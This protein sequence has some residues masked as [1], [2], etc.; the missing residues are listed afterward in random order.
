MA[1]ATFSGCVVRMED[2]NG[3]G[4]SGG[5]S[6]QPCAAEALSDAELTAI[7]EQARTNLVA[8]GTEL[9]RDTWG[10]ATKFGAF[11]AE[12]YALAGCSPQSGL[13]QQALHSDD[14]PDFYCGSGHGLEKLAT[15][16]V[17]QCMNDACRLHDACYAMCDGP[18][19]GCEFDSNMAPCDE[20]F[21][22]QIEACPSEPGT[23]L[24]SGMVEF[25][26]NILYVK[27]SLFSCG[28]MKCPELGGPGTGVCSTDPSGAD[29]KG[30][31][32][33]TDRGNLCFDAACA[34]VPGDAVCY[35]AN[36]PEVSECYGGYG[37]GVPGGVPPKNP[38]AD[39]DSVL[40]DLHLISG[41]LPFTKP[42][43]SDW[44]ADAFGWSPPDPY[45]V[46]T[47]GTETGQTDS[48]EDVFKP[49]WHTK[50]L[51]AVTAQS[52]RDGITFEVWDEDV[53][54]DDSV[55]AC[56]FEM[57][58]DTFNAEY[59]TASCDST[60]LKVHFYVKRAQ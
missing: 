17:S 16:R 49:P 15:P 55:G 58:N 29:C 11:S 35:A 47:V 39:P 50:V 12:V 7:Y 8:K 22:K 3:S 28:D 53:F 32:S 20:P 14:G 34:D 41:E 44:D 36:C 31:L 59:L 25:I 60:G 26:A 23:R 51:T 5:G 18:S 43:G 9:D 1:I 52:L 57:S 4:G 6:A 19:K 56:H 45:V 33:E 48:P 2:Q 38:V 21:L 30:C 54:D 42:D 37:L 46:V 40:W 10:D 13:A 24:A 27:G